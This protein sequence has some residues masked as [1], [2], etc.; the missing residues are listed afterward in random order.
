MI[1]PWFLDDSLMTL[2]WLWD[3]NSN[4]QE[5]DVLK[6]ITILSELRIGQ[7]ERTLVGTPSQAEARNQPSHGSYEWIIMLEKCGRL[8]LT[9]FHLIWVIGAYGNW[10]DQNPQKLGQ[11][12][13][14]GS[15][16]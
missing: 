6:I 3:E 9:V 7:N 10:K 16:V 14:I 5:A 1:F 2:G 11:M 13:W 15:P 12:N 4:L 8:D